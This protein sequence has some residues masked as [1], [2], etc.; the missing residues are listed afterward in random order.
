[1]PPP[2]I[3]DPNLIATSSVLFGAEEI[4]R[5]NPQR[6]EMEQLTAIVYLDRES[7]VVAGYRDVR[8]DE[9]WIRGH[10]PDFPL[11]P[12]VLICEAAAQLC[13]FYTQLVNPLPHGFLGFGGMDDVRF[14]RPVRPGDRLLLAGKAERIRTRQ[15]VFDA[16][17]FV[18]TAMAFYARI[19]G[20][21]VSQAT[22]D[23]SGTMD[24]DR[25]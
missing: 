19:I 10:M 3:I 13:G 23:E 24:E 2:A 16:Q 20:I 9:F 14:L 25:A 18:G 8:P 5:C 17:G 22:G 15:C 1:M 12:G 4:R 21:P 7:H 6:L 11:M